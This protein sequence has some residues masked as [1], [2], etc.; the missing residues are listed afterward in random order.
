MIGILWFVLLTLDCGSSRPC[1]LPVCE[2]QSR[3]KWPNWPHVQHVKRSLSCRRRRCETAFVLVVTVISPA[4]SSFTFIASLSMSLGCSA[5]IA[6]A[7][8]VS[9]LCP[10]VSF[11]TSAAVGRTDAIAVAAVT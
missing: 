8:P 9:P 11:F 1:W 2:W 10:A 4:N 5:Y 3:L 7:D 6:A